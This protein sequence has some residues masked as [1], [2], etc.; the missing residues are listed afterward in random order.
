MLATLGPDGAPDLV[1]V[2]F[3]LA[4]GAVDPLIVT[5]VDH[6][7]KR[8]ERLARIVNIAADPRVTLLADCW[9]DD[10]GRLWWVRAVG[11]A[12]VHERDVALPADVAA[13]FA[14][15]VDRYPPYREQPPAGPVIAATITRWVGWAAQ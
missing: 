5:A 14:A 10:W 15:L 8:T 4:D 13:T 3:A 12:E 9:D 6:K 7:P 11:R 1:P 2:T